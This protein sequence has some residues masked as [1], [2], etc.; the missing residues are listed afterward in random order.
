M[1]NTIAFIKQQ[2]T[3]IE[4]KLTAG[5]HNF[6]DFPGTHNEGGV[7]RKERHSRAVVPEGEGSEGL[8]GDDRNSGSVAGEHGLEEHMRARDKEVDEWRQDGDGGAQKCRG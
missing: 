6:F 3:L 7:R 1:E 8:E 5:L 4:G 2:M